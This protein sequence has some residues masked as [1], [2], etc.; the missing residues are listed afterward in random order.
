MEARTT[1]EWMDAIMSSPHRCRLE[2]EKEEEV[3]VVDVLVPSLSLPL[4]LMHRHYP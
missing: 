4:A 2:E 1:A 3:V